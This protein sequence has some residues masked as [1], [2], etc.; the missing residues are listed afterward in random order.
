MAINTLE[1]LWVLLF[2]G[3]PAVIG[4]FL[5]RNRGRNIIGW[6]LVCAVFPF[7]LFILYFNKPL[8]DVPGHFRRCQSC[9][10]FI[11]W[12]EVECR[13]CKAPQPVE[14]SEKVS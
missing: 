2:F 10:E 8:R 7:F 14:P 13:Y 6:P 9:Q 11:P 5:A 4:F 1:L 12:K 3:I